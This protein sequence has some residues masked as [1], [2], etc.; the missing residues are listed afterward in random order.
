MGNSCAHFDQ[1]TPSCKRAHGAHEGSETR[2]NFLISSLSISCSSV[3]EVGP[4]DFLS[5]AFLY[6]GVY[7]YRRGTSGG[8]SVV[9]FF[10]RDEWSLSLV[11]WQKTLDRS[12][13]GHS[14][15][16]KL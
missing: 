6:V 16:P 11:A 4:N 1:R 7:F 9:T 8:S 5:Y 10:C 2:L 12:A 3:P 15:L 14:P 13:T